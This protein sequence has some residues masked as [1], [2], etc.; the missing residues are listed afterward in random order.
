MAF[1]V[2]VVMCLDQSRLSLRVTTSIS[3]P[4]PHQVLVQKVYMSEKNGELFLDT[5]RIKGE[6]SVFKKKYII[7]E[8]DALSEYNKIPLSHNRTNGAVYSK[9]ISKLRTA[10]HFR[11]SIVI[12]CFISRAI[13]AHS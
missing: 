11:Y 1:V 9:Y 7:D 12:P 4:R 8:N 3:D 5:T 10:L 6:C 2:V 13:T